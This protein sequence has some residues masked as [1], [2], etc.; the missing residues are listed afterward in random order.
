MNSFVIGIIA[1]GM[2]TRSAALMKL[3]MEHSPTILDVLTCILFGAI[4]NQHLGTQSKQA[5]C[6]IIELKISKKEKETTLKREGLREE[7]DENNRTKIQN[8]TQQPLAKGRSN[9]KLSSAGT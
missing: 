7:T 9:T 1:M 3:A 5:A 4:L 2:M 6:W 8:V